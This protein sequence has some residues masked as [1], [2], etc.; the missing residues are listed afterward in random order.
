[1]SKKEVFVEL[2]TGEKRQ[3][4]FSQTTEYLTGLNIVTS[5]MVML[6]R[7]QSNCAYDVIRAG[8]AFFQRIDMLPDPKEAFAFIS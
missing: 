6:D 8:F 3:A 2:M 5:A 1:M 4:T 7:G